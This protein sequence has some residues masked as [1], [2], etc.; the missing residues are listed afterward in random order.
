MSLDSENKIWDNRSGY[1]IVSRNFH[2]VMAFLFALQFGISFIHLLLKGSAID[3]LLWTKHMQ[4]GVILLLLVMFRALWGALNIVGRPYEVSMAGRLAVLG[5]L[6]IYALMF[7]VPALALLRS[8]G[9]GRGFSFLGIELFQ[10]TGIVNETLTAPGDAL[11]SL[12][13][14][15]LLVTVAGHASIALIHHFVLRDDTLRYMAGRKK[16]GV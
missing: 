14:W 16:T 3:D 8:Y 1:G 10:Q 6:A 15:V 5:H 2:W 7:V 12:L 11:H 13:G 4:L 9:R